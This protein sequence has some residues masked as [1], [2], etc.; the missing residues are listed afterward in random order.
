LIHCPNSESQCSALQSVMEKRGSRIHAVVELVCDHDEFLSERV[1]TKL[2]QISNPKPRTH[3]KSHSAAFRWR[4]LHTQTCHAA[5]THWQV[6]AGSGRTYNTSFDAPR[7]E[8]VDDVT[9]EP[10]EHSG[11][12]FVCFAG[13]VCGF[14]L[15][16]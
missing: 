16:R 8:G 7:E 15:L 6:H 13:V 1:S 11:E 12:A 3:L 4:Q 9:G 2:V 10:L 14:C 5:H